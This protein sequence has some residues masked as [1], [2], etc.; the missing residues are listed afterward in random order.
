MERYRLF[1]G[2]LR[3]HPKGEW[4]AAAD[5]EQLCQR[6]SRLDY[7]LTLVCTS[8]WPHGLPPAQPGETLKQYILRIAGETDAD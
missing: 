1:Q 6:I 4:V 2:K 5:A 3:P 7:A 8:A